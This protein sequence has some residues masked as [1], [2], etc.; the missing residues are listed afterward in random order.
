MGDEHSKCLPIEAVSASSS[1]VIYRLH[2][3]L[4][5]TEGPAPDCK[6]FW[7]YGT[8]I[9]PTGGFVIPHCTTLTGDT[10]HTLLTV[11]HKCR[12]DPVDKRTLRAVERAFS[13]TG[14]KPRDRV[15]GMAIETA[16]GGVTI[17]YNDGDPFCDTLQSAR[18][19][20]TTRR[21]PDVTHSF[22]LPPTLFIGPNEVRAIVCTL[23]AAPYSPCLDLF[24]Y[25]ALN[26]RTF[27]VCDE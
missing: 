23:R 5:P 21:K 14:V 24:D 16:V 18:L 4:D 7:S 17:R 13:R 10:M 19:T 22:V 20:F 25:V 2:V 27:R 12:T 15:C 9:S 6:G 8:S 11:L 1:I 26:R 3:L